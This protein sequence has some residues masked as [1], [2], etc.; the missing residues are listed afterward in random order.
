[1]YDCVATAR[2]CGHGSTKV[3]SKEV[4]LLEKQ[5]Y[6]SRLSPLGEFKRAGSWLLEDNFPE[7][8]GSHGLVRVWA[9]VRGCRPLVLPRGPA[10]RVWDC[11]A[12]LGA[13]NHR[14]RVGGSVGQNKEVGKRVGRIVWSGRMEKGKICAGKYALIEKPLYILNSRDQQKYSSSVQ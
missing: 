10:E 8:R 14:S 1:M 11:E 3:E 6:G 2:S 13:S 9:M 5:K 7:G 12:L 4:N